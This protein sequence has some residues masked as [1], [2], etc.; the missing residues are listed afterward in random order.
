MN[1]MKSVFAMLRRTAGGD[2]ASMRVRTARVG[3]PLAGLLV[4]LLTMQSS[5][6]ADPSVEKANGQLQSL[7]DVFERLEDFEAFGQNLPLSQL[8]PADALKLRDIFDDEAPDLDSLKDKLADSSNN[9]FAALAATLDELDGPYGGIDVE[10]SGP[11]DGPDDAVYVNDATPGAT[12]IVDLAFEITATREVNIPLAFTNSFVTLNG[13]AADGAYKVV[14]E[15]ATTVLHFQFDKALAANAA[16]LSQS[17]WLRTMPTAAA[18]PDAARRVAPGL[19][20]SV[21]SANATGPA[22]PGATP[23]DAAITSF[24]ANLGI[25]TVTVTG[26]AAFDLDFGLTFLDPDDDDGAGPNGDQKIT[27]DEWTVTDLDDLTD[28][29]VR[30]D[31]TTDA[32]KATITLDTTLI[33]ATNPDATITITDASL[34]APAPPASGFNPVITTAPDSLGSLG[35]FRNFTAADALAAVDRLVTF[36]EGLQ[37]AGTL[38]PQLPFVDGAPDP[39]N[40]LNESPLG[41]FSDALKVAQKLKNAIVAPVSGLRKVVDD[42]ATSVN[43]I[44][45]PTFTTLAQLGTKLGTALGIG[46]LVPAYDPTSRRLSFNL[47]FSDSRNAPINLDFSNLDILSGYVRTGGAGTIAGAVDLDLDFALDLSPQPTEDGAGPGSCADGIDNAADDGNPAT[48]ADGAD[49]GDGVTTPTNTTTTDDECANSKNIEER[50][51]VEV[52]T[53]ANAASPELSARA[54]VDVT[55]V[56]AS[57]MIG[58][59][60]AGIDNARLRVGS[61]SG[62]D[63]SGPLG[64]ESC[65]D[66]INQGGTGTD[67]ADPACALAI[68]VDFFEPGAGADGWLTIRELF[69]GMSPD[70]V[71][72]GGARMA[73]TLDAAVDALVPV[74]AALGGVNLVGGNI[75]VSGGYSGPL[76]GATQLVENTVVNASGVHASDLFDFSPCTNPLDDDGDG[77]AN[78][79]CPKVG[80]VAESGPQCTNDTDDAVTGEATLDG[81]VNDG[82]PAVDDSETESLGMLNKI[83]DAI[84][85]LGAEVKKSGLVDGETPLPLVGGNFNDLLDVM[86]SID[87]LADSLTNK[88][89]SEIEVPAG[90]PN[91]CAGSTVAPVVPAVDD[92]FD[93]VVNDGC[94]TTPGPGGTDPDRPEADG[95]TEDGVTRNQCTQSPAVDDDLDGTINDGCPPVSTTL[96]DIADQIDKL[97][98]KGLEGLPG[99][100]PTVTVTLKIDNDSDVNAANPINTAAGPNVNELVFRVDVD[101]PNIGRNL[102]FTLDLGAAGSF[103]AIDAAGEL[104]AEIDGDLDLDFGLDLDTLQPFL[105]GSSK[106]VLDAEARAENLTFSAA[107]GPIQVLVGQTAANE[108]GEDEQPGGAACDDATDSDGDGVVNDGCPTDP[109]VA[110]TGSQCTDAVDAEE[111]PDP[112]PDT[113]GNQAADKVNDGCPTVASKG[114]AAIGATLG[115]QETGAD[116]VKAYLPGFA[117]AGAPTIAFGPDAG[118]EILR[119]VQPAQC[120][121]V[122][123]TG[124]PAGDKVACASLP[125]YY[126]V[127]DADAI[128]PEPLGS[129]PSANKLLMVMTELLPPN[130]EVDYDFSQLE[131][132]VQ[133]A[134]IDLL[135]LNSGFDDLLALLEDLLEN[136]L[137]GINLPLIGDQLSNAADIVKTIRTKVKTAITAGL[138]G[139]NPV[140]A[141]FPASAIREILFDVFQ[142][143]D[144]DGSVAKSLVS[145][146]ILRDLATGLTA[147]AAGATQ[148]SPGDLGVVMLCGTSPDKKC[149]FGAE[150]DPANP[151]VTD[152]TPANNCDGAADDD[153]DGAVNDGCGAEGAAESG[154][155]CNDNVDNDGDGKV[156]DGC[157]AKFDGATKIVDIAFRA[158]LGQ[159]VNLF[160]TAPDPND[161]TPGFD[162]GIPGLGLSGDLRLRGDINW[163]F[164]LGFGISKDDGFYFKTNPAGGDPE[165]FLGA[166]ML[167]SE[168]GTAAPSHL[169]ATLGF[170]RVIAVD[171][172][173]ALACST[174]AG[175]SSAAG[176]TPGTSGD[177]TARDAK[178]RF[179]VGFEVDV[180]DPNADG[181]LTFTELSQAQSFTDILDFKLGATADV[182]LHLQTLLLNDAS[183]P[184]VFADLHL[185]WTWNILPGAGSTPEDVGTAGTAACTIGSGPSCLKLSVDDI[186]F[187]AGSF[188]SKFLIPTLKDVQRYTKPLDPVIKVLTTPIPVLS[189]LSGSPVTLLT[190]VETFGPKD[191]RLE[192]VIYLVKIIDFVN[193]FNFTDGDHMIA[194]SKPP[195]NGGNVFAL[196]AEKLYGGELRDGESQQA[197]GAGQLAGMTSLLGSGVLGGTNVSSGGSVTNVGQLV[198][199]GFSFPFLEQPSKIVGLLFKQDVDLIIFRA[200]IEASFSY[201]QKFGP[202]WALPP[203]FIEVGGSARI[204]GHFGIGYDTQGLREVLFEGANGWALLNGLF[205]EDRRPGATVDSPEL[206]IEMR[207]FVNAQVSVL[208]F[209]AGAEG[210]FTA[211]IALDL[212]DPN[213]DGRLKFPEAAEIIRT[214]G[215]PLCLFN[216]SGRF[217]VEV[218][219]FAEVDL[220][221]W[222]Q[223]W[224]KVLA[225]VVL[226]EFKVSCGPLKEPTLA[227]PVGTELLLNIGDREEFRGGAGTIG[228]NEPN[229]TFVVTKASDIYDPVGKVE[230]A[231]VRVSAFGTTTGYIGD[232][233]KI[234]VPDALDGVD[235]ITLADGVAGAEKLC[236]SN[237]DD[238]GDGKIND[239]CPKVGAAA[240]TVSQCLNDT[241]DDSDGKVNDGCKTIGDPIPFNIPSDVKLGSGNDQF[242]GGHGRDVVDGGADN[243]VINGRDGDNVLVGGP[244]QDKLGALQGADRLYGDNRPSGVGAETSPTTEQGQSETDIVGDFD[245][246]DGGAGADMLH[247]GPGAD[248]LNGGLTSG[249]LVDAVDTIYGNGGNDTI[250]AGDDS[251][252]VYAGTGAD[253]VSGGPGNDTISG[254][255]EADGTC[256]GGISDVLIGGPG[257]DSI[258]AGGGDD[259]VIGGSN[260]AGIADVGDTLLDGGGGCDYIFGDNATFTSDS[261]PRAFTLVDPTIGGGETSIVGGAG[262]DVIHGQKGADTITGNDGDDDLFGED[263]DDILS[264]NAGADELFGAVGDDDLS[265]GDGADNIYGDD[266]LD[267]LIGDDGSVT[268]TGARL[269]HAVVL[270]ADGTQGTGNDVML[271]G[272]DRDRLYGQGGVDTMFGDGGDDDVHGGRGNDIMRGNIGSDVMSGGDGADTIAGDSGADRIVGGSSTMTANLNTASEPDGGLV[273]DPDRPA[274]Q[275]NDQ[276]DGGTGND[277]IAGDSADVTSTATTLLSPASAITLLSP[278][279]IG[280]RDLIT[281]DSGED[282]I[283]SGR[284]DDVVFGGF[285]D[286]YIEG[287]ADKDSLDGDEGDDDIIGGTSQA[288]D[289]VADRDAE[290]EGGQSD[291]ND[292][293]TGDSGADVILGDNGRIVRTGSPS[294]FLSGGE[295]RDVELFDL[296]SKNLALSGLDS[297]TGDL[298]NDQVFGGGEKDTIHGNEGDDYA[299]GNGGAD[300]IWGDIGQ[301]D[302]IGG[303]SSSAGD[304]L[305][306]AHPDG[307]DTIVG[308]DGTGSD[309]L[310]V[311]DA[312]VIAGDNASITR[313]E[314]GGVT[315]VVV[316]D[317][318]D[319][320]RGFIDVVRRRIMLFDVATVGV[321]NPLAPDNQPVSGAETIYGEADYDL[322][323]GQGGNDELHGGPSDDYLEGGSGVDTIYGEAGQDDILGGTG[324]TTSDDPATA[325]DGR[326]DGADLLYGADGVVNAAADDAT[327]VDDFDVIMGDNATI[328]RDL[329]G[330]DQV[331]E[332]NSFNASIRRAVFL[333]DVASVTNS[334]SALTSGG[335]TMR[336]EADADLMYGQGASDVMEG[337]GGDD[338]MEGNAANDT[339]RGHVGNDDIIGG[340]GRINTDP[341]AGTNGRLDS[342]ETLIAGGPGFDTIGGDN[343][344][345]VRVLTGAG[346]WV[347][348][349]FNAGIQHETIRLLDINSPNHL[350]VSGGE[351]IIEGN[352]DDD[353]MYGQGGDDTMRGNDG[354]DYMEGNAADDN[355]SGD[356]GQDD[357]VGGTG[358][359]GLDPAT[360]VDGRFDGV[361]LISGEFGTAEG[362]TNGS[363]GDFIVGD[364]AVV[365]RPLTNDLWTVQP[366]NQVVQ[367][368]HVLNDQE[369][370]A[371]PAVSDLVHGGD[372]IYGNDNDDTVYAQGGPDTVFGNAGDDFLFGNSDTDTIH[373]NGDQ[374]DI[375]GGN[376]VAGQLDKNDF[377]YGDGEADFMLGDN[378]VI[379]RPLS[380]G[381]WRTFVEANTSTILRKTVRFDVNGDPTSFGGDYIEGNGGDDTQWGQDGNDTMHGNADNDDMYGELGADRMFGGTGEDAMLG[382]RGGIVN[383]RIDG[384]AGDPVSTTVSIQAPPKI[385]YTSFRSGSLDRRFDLRHD[386]DADA[387]LIGAAMPFPGISVGGDD[388]MLGGP[389]HDSMHGGFGQDVMNGESGG[390]TLFGDD[391]ADAMWGGRG[392]DPEVGDVDCGVF[393]E[394][395]GTDDKYVDYLFGGHGL[396]SPNPAEAAAD[397]LDYRPRG[398]AAT[399]ATEGP[400]DSFDPCS[401]L[402]ATGSLDGIDTNN[403]HHQ[404]IDWIYGGWDRDVMQADVADE[405]PN[406]GDRLL[407]WTGVYNLYTH[408]NP[409]YGGFNDVREF[410][411]AFKAFL[412]KWAYGVGAG[413]DQ[414]NVTAAGQSGFRELGLVHQKDIKPNSGKAFSTTPG[415]FDDFSCAP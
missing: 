390:D 72:Q 1:G 90:A 338:Y 296:D 181:R 55:N 21:A 169:E 323:Y 56:D 86:D 231:G 364:N 362:L 409:A 251:D 170:L 200:S 392:C 324:R 189:D 168:P 14:F 276:I 24:T 81:A 112:D 160:N 369:L 201:S 151:A 413:P 96:Q 214:T 220:L 274:V 319:T 238:D 34:A 415:H 63:G 33:S 84:R 158:R 240:E 326:L 39:L 403:Q 71:T 354:D 99:P 100:T 370:V 285:D 102:P 393:L 310:P 67:L 187:D 242:T 28:F 277:L 165:V 212:E 205:L 353:V 398:T 132:I 44:G 147:G 58:L 185:D 226:F 273:N 307:S 198:Q 194:L 12:G 123:F 317:D 166:T 128:K 221:F 117:P 159:S 223:K 243:D 346:Q 302:L 332:V 280:A 156:N 204:F 325:G 6:A 175:R 320:T 230:R 46:A 57:V 65:F 329:V 154:T 407:D 352:E 53:V 217:A 293:I 378:G 367:R 10:V 252:F 139:D 134:A 406:E 111:E 218:S 176:C 381:S 174:P 376:D 289:V 267:I 38:D 145:A 92:D 351:V 266:G 202:I 312:D 250:D 108:T 322:I 31:A 3:V 120:A 101:A 18:V 291:D 36:L 22:A 350:V 279:T 374:D 290:G 70:P 261:N 188:I 232:F 182:N 309:T 40:P 385:S 278:A 197:F 163:R 155:D 314:S 162:I 47:D 400:N 54:L 114:F 414:V 395:R 48:P 23:V 235:I 152:D 130:P 275:R 239:G 330:N 357:I 244:G 372:T 184:R 380:A 408:C 19:N 85:L 391:G 245:T 222:S 299:E 311:P 171:G 127:N 207:L 281:G 109:D 79:G 211:N 124:A 389:D 248:T 11:A 375:T 256:A 77:K 52:G 95:I 349:T 270:A 368:A 29:A 199:T 82:C 384:S 80:A 295:E 126:D 265:G 115:I 288:G 264:G 190:L 355:I 287:N 236:D 133:S 394:A 143:D 138:A 69:N 359:V 42:P 177:G 94:P 229:E 386:I 193:G 8:K 304:D 257:A 141:A 118:T 51:S 365:S 258:T 50:V 373:G 195:A 411:P 137:F 192:L 283:L 253:R 113:A 402:E 144:A 336:G 286:D 68:G 30:D 61:R 348:N 104:L 340:T 60:E 87:Q 203:V 98:T 105:L 25:T 342:G 88:A 7:F 73:A 15:L 284:G 59:L 300:D 16:T 358:R 74:G 327:G 269:A 209:S 225:E 129:L 97:L 272:G 241:D 43:E 315:S 216:L 360:G 186:Y 383:R 379:T 298:T 110:E 377:L 339:I 388:F 333:Y 148:A 215:N 5:Q 206:G 316:K 228:D 382:D 116:N 387:F 213:G 173:P 234:V 4:L 91:P 297:I 331:W 32:I 246:L 103:I 62:E 259:L 254:G 399:C 292:T 26:T 93:G 146:G 76:A 178:S 405:G 66:G 306:G 305:G 282:R 135:L 303:T 396:N 262:P 233:T 196:A 208:I 153:G 64:F 142:A 13:G 404:G 37:A 237:V 122:T 366:F 410:S 294:T 247:G 119:G 106:L 301:D 125:L 308:G 328:L 191:P 345:I 397:F 313:F 179:T 78:D 334:V 2:R 140:D 347:T 363:G 341:P 172:D 227:T 157:A 335:D 219:V 180:S 49:A 210:A 131:A 9:T 263:G 20:L 150:N 337:N 27:A 255:N 83:I 321:P 121:G 344:I 249:P 268:R 35:D 161:P 401:W 183:L 149:D 224:T 89:E 356:A 271:G 75:T 371:G 17:L 260:L 107:F 318:L 41:S 136:Q 45:N 164:D 412:E 343:S 361:D 167:L